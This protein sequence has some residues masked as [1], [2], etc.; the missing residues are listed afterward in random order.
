MSGGDHPKELKKCTD[1]CR[2]KAS[3]VLPNL[4]NSNL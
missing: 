3:C 2:M 4:E 1:D